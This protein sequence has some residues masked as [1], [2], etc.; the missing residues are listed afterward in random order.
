MYSLLLFFV[1]I[2][3]LVFWFFYNRNIFFI[4][5]FGYIGTIIIFLLIFIISREG[6]G[7]GAMFFV[8]FFASLYGYYFSVIAFL[9]SFWFASLVLIIP[10]CLK[11]IDKKTK[12]PLIP[13]LFIGCFITIIIGFVVSIK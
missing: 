6:I 2:A 3:S 4:C 8:G 5:F 12:I 11:K 1:S 7:L 13:F 10:Y 9:I